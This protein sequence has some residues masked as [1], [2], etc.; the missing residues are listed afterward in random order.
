MGEWICP[1]CEGGFPDSAMLDGIACPWCHQ[2]IYDTKSQ[3][4]SHLLTGVVNAGG[5]DE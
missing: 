1:A 2:M 4:V 5:S 3:E